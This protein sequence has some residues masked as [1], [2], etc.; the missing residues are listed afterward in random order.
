MASQPN[1]DMSF[2]ISP[3]STLSHR[4]RKH[5]SS[6]SSSTPLSLPLPPPPSSSSV[7]DPEIKY[8][9][10]LSF[11][12]RDVRSGF[13]SHLQKK[14][15][16]KKIDYFVDDKKLEQGD[17]IS[18]TLLNAIKKSAISLVVFSKR[19]PS[20]KWCLEELEQIIR[21]RE[22]QTQIVIPIFYKIDPT[23]VRHQSGGYKNAFDKLGKKFDKYR[24]QK[25]QSALTEASNLSGF[26][27]S[28]Y[29]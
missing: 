1:S 29:Q 28:T 7:D 22:N 19:Y 10:F 3:A 26:H 18:S 13:L 2:S 15:S 9:V 11:R 24:L 5:T 27:S 4:K 21:C 8:D 14:L 23:T 25:W 17:E 12:G 20:S 16:H 6:S